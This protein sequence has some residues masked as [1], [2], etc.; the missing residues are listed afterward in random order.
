M[1][2]V[3]VKKT[4]WKSLELPLQRKTINQKQHTENGE[5]AEISAIIK[6]LKDAWVVVHTLSPFFIY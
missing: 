2:D 3:M 5:I 1:R 6:D 4:K